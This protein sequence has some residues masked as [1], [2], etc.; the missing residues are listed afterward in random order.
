MALPQTGAPVVLNET[1]TV[2]WLRLETWCQ[3]SDLIAALGVLYPDVAPGSIV[4]GVEAV[5][6]SL[7]EGDLLEHAS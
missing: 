6:S 7:E 5:I 2:L 1:A 4:K 3:P